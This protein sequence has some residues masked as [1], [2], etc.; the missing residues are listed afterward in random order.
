V[1]IENLEIVGVGFF[2]VEFTGLQSAAATYGLFPGDLDFN[3]DEGAIPA[4]DAITAAFNAVGG[5]LGVGDDG[6]TNPS[7]IFLIGFDVEAII[8]GNDRI[9]AY[10]GTA[11]GDSWSREGVESL[12]YNNA[13]R[14]WATF[15]PAVPEPGSA[16]L[17]GLGLVGLGT[18]R[19]RKAIA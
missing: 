3:T 15:T 12:F 9:I 1:R 6:L 7:P 13:D 19:R 16:L 14:V 4:V 2:D 10:P 5:V 8:G 11:T 17:L 18:V